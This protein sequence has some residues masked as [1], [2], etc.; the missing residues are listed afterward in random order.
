[1][2]IQPPK[3]VATPLPLCHQRTEAKVTEYHV[4][5]AYDKPRQEHRR[6]SL[7]NVQQTGKNS[8]FLTGG[9]EH[10]GCADFAATQLP[11]IHSSHPLCEK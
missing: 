2:A 8:H 5:L 9:T 11:H 1:M 3:K 10:I 6:R 7:Y 4:A